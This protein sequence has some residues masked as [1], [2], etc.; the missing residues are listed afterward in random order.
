MRIVTVYPNWANVGGAQNVAFRLA[1]SLNS[2]EGTE[3]LVLCEAP[4]RVIDYY[5]RDGVKYQRVG[6]SAFLRLEQEDVVLSHDRKWTTL[7]VFW[8]AVFRRKLRIIHIAHSVFHNKRLWTCFPPEIV[9]VST[10]VK[11]NLVN[12]FR[13]NPNRIKVIHNGLLDAA[14]GF[15]A[16]RDLMKEHQIRILF[17]GRVC[18]VKQQLKFVEHLSTHLPEHIQVYFAGDGEDLPTLR[19]RTQNLSQFHVLGRVNLYEVLP[20][21]DYVCLFSEKEGLP[22]TLIEGC[23]FSKPL[24]TNGLASVCDVNHD[25]VNGFVFPTWSDLVKGLS[26][27]SQA[28]SEAYQRLSRASRQIYEV[29]F[30]EERMLADYERLIQNQR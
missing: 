5:L 30:T 4:E 9:A 6:L 15:T 3:P 19:Q 14:G 13:C 18:P 23:M 26:F 11:E 7:F 16:H 24:I 12:Y 2:N 29:H 25:G 10:G 8:N 27:I 22:L 17:A 28:D 20:Q 21:Y 1:V